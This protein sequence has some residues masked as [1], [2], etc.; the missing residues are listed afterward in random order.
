MLQAFDG[1]RTAFVK[2][3][4]LPLGTELRKDRSE[5]DDALHHRPEL[6]PHRAFYDLVADQ[7]ALRTLLRRE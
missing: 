6:V 1:D 4:D 7:R 2:E 3:I 5:P